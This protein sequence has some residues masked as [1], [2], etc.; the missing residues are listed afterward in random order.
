MK[1]KPAGS[2]EGSGRL[3]S[4]GGVQNRIRV[5]ATPLTFTGIA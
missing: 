2:R 1:K 3:G 5:F 4:F